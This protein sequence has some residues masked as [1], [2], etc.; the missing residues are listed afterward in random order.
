[1]GMVEIVVAGASGVLGRMICTEAQRIF[2]D[3]VTVVV[4]DRRESR[5]RETAAGLGG[6]AR[7]VVMDVADDES[8]RTGLRG[9]DLVI[10]AVGQ[11]KP[12]V[13]DA[14]IQLG[15]PCVDVTTDAEVVARVVER[16]DEA[17]RSKVALVVMA[18]LFPGLSGLLAQQA[19][20]SLD[21]VDRLDIALRQSTN[22][23]VGPSGVADML[24]IVS[25]PVHGRPGFRERARLPFRSGS[26]AV[27]R[28]AHAEQRVLT[29]EI[30]V[31]DVAYWTAW[32]NERFNRM[33]GALIRARVLPRMASAFAVLA[34]HTPDRPQRVE[35]M[36]RAGGRVDGEA[37]DRI[38]QLSADSDYGATATVA[39]AL[40][41][42][43]LEQRWAGS[44]PPLR[45]ST[46]GAVLARASTPGITMSESRGTKRS[47]PLD[48]H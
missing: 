37:A 24:R 36:A 8:V 10:V 28:I 34:Q 27:R 26:A 41:A 45:F 44:G 18:G 16:D 40:G 48:G 11:S 12:R 47:G 39:A 9:A 35:L 42:M 23:E 2:G 33:V 13:Q 21:S 46:L 43:A 30:G 22:A 6:R 4:G 20:A 29:E 19:A 3:D 7:S 14:C 38:V 32:D 1:M 15:V 31:S 5:G 17:R 25:A